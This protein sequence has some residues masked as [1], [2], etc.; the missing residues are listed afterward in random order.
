MDPAVQLLRILMKEVFLR[1]V[2]FTVVLSWGLYVY[3]S[4]LVDTSL[5]II[6]PTFMSLKHREF[7]QTILVHVQIICTGLLIPLWPGYKGSVVFSSVVET[8]H[9]CPHY[10]TDH[11]FTWGV[12]YCNDSNCSM[13]TVQITLYTTHTIRSMYLCPENLE[14]LVQYIAVDHLSP[15]IRLYTTSS[16]TTPAFSGVQIAGR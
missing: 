13:V 14:S 8:L 1:V 9:C 3:D 2:G 11:L 12:Q 7:S 5:F 4:M 6:P 16:P 10:S 15:G